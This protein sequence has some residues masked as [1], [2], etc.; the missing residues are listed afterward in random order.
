MA[1]HLAR[2]AAGMLRLAPLSR[3]QSISFRSA[4]LASSVTRQSHSRG[5]GLR[6]YQHGSYRNLG[7]VLLSPPR[8]HHL[9]QPSARTLCD[10]QY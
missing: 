4:M 2:M 5:L 1:K 8:Y 7:A 10:V 9:R 3:E 6:G